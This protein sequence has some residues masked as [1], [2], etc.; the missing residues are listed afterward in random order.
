MKQTLL[1]LLGFAF[2]L[3]ALFLAVA[4]TLEGL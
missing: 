1:M 2:C 4:T 3:F